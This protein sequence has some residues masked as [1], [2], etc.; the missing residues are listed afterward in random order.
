VVTT[1]LAFRHVYLLHYI[2]KGEEKNRKAATF[3]T[4]QT[5]VS[6]HSRFVFIVFFEFISLPALVDRRRG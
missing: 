1:Y 3:Y 5:L 2:I 6:T 4:A